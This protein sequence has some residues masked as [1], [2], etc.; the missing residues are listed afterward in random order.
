[1]LLTVRAWNEAGRALAVWTALQMDLSR[2]H[3][4]AELRAA[5]DGFV[6]QLTPVVKA[7]LSDF[8]L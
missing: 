1:M 4:D 5:A 2:H 7:A 3:P 6:A 8:G